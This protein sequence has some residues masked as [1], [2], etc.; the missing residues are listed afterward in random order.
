M[1]DTDSLYAELKPEIEALAGPLFEVS[2]GFVR[3][4]GAFLPHGAALDTNGA[5]RMVMAAPP[6]FEKQ[7]VSTV[8]VLPM[9]HEG[10]FGPKP[11]MRISRPSQSAKTSR[12]S[13]KGGRKRPRSKFW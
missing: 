8:D 9:L 11:A 13:S 2:D 12:L 6:G 1:T 4:R 7:P 5:A 3:Q 10:R